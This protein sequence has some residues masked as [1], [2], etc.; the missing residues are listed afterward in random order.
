MQWATALSEAR[1]GQLVLVAT[2]IGNLGDPPHGPVTCWRRRTSSAARTRAEPGPSSRHWVSPAGRR[3]PFALAA[4]AQRSRPPRTR[5]GRRGRRSDGGGGQRCGDAR[6]F[7]PR[8]LARAAARRGGETVSTVPGPSSVLGALVVSGL[9]AD[10]FCV[11]GFL[12]RKGPSAS[13]HRR[14]HGGRAHLRRARGARGRRDAG[15][16]GRGDPTP[17][18]G[19]GAGADQ[20]ARRGLAGIARR[21]GDGLRGTRGAGRGGPGHRW[22]PPTV[23]AGEEEVDERYAPHWETIRRRGHARSPTVWPPPSE[24]R[25]GAPT[26]RPRARATADGREGTSGHG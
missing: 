4:R 3:R 17:A 1:R 26:R 19:G 9:P 20:A 15:R 18:G 5:R 7:G 8:R 11:E 14:A 25:G 23:A 10:R 21:R 13:A 12:P 6:H 24:C 22:R 2:P 16:G